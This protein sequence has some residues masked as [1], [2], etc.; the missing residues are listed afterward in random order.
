ME[1][2][3][4]SLF[5]KYT[6]TIAKNFKIFILHDNDRHTDTIN[7]DVEMTLHTIGNN[8]IPKCNWQN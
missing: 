7:E 2:F 5:E 6:I 1:L 3:L 8:L 4:K